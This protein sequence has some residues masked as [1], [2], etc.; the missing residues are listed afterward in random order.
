M[1]NVRDFGAAGDGKTDDTEAI[2]HA[3]EQGEGVLEFPPG[4]YRLTHTIRIELD[5]RGRCGL[6]G[7]GGGARILMDGPGPAFHLIGTHAGTAS[8]ASLR[9][10]TR[11]RE[12]MPTVLNLQI[13]GRQAEA[14]GFLLE[15]TIM[16]TFEG[17]LLN[18]L[19][20]GI[21]LHKRNRNVLISHC[22]IYNNR[23]VGVY[24]DHVNL[25][26]IIITGSHIS[27]NPVAGIKVEG[28]EIRNFQFTGN[29]IEYNYSGEYE[30]SADVLIDCRPEGSTIREGT[31]VSNTIQARY[32]PGG[33]NVR[34]IGHSQEQSHKAGLLTI[35][36]NLLGSQEVGV[37]LDSCRGVVVTGNVIYSGHKRNLLIERSRNIVVGPNSFDHNPDYGRNELCTG[38]RIADSQDVTLSGIQI[39]DGQEGRHTVPGTIP[40]EREALLEIVNSR[41]ITASGLHILDGQPYGV[42][43]DNSHDVAITGTLVQE[44]REQPLSQ[45]SIRWKAPGSGNLLASCRFGQAKLEIDDEAGVTQQANA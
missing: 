42:L 6:V 27:Y 38:I 15:G 31:I 5:K 7:L 33:A 9:P 34:V 13:E 25:H 18:Q 21:R 36:D 17:V 8:P 16:A 29:D 39:H 12:R 22:H 35:S 30:E 28:G 40:L 4:D 2:L 14:D 23:R 24:L 20:D 3:L 11:E 41:R 10:I 44:T 45:A 43:V 1:S 26:Q 32:S 37:H 19:R